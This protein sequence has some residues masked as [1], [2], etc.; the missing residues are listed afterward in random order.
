MKDVEITD[1]YPNSLLLEKHIKFIAA[2]SQKKDDYVSTFVSKLQ[3][4][5][6]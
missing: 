2:Y 4:S 3:T 5:G 1:K 6:N